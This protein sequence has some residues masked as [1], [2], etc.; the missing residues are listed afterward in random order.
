MKS[1]LSHAARATK[2]LTW[3]GGVTPRPAD[4]GWPVDLAERISCQ[5]PSCRDD[6]PMTG[7]DN[8]QERRD[9]VVIQW[10]YLTRAD[11]RTWHLA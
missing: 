6:C 9:V 10:R 11:S 5:F 7:A 2:Q 8:L 4:H 3:L 1:F